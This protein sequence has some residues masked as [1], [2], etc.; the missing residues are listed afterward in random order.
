MTKTSFSKVTNWDD[1]GLTLKLLMTFLSHLEH[2]YDAIIQKNINQDAMSKVF[3]FSEAVTPG[4]SCV[5]C[6]VPLWSSC[7]TMNY[8]LASDNLLQEFP[9][10]DSII[11]GGPL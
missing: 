9:D 8:F 6:L 1:N 2:A 7:S 10:S 4:R 11:H 5:S 3:S